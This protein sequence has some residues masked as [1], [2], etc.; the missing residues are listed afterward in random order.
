VWSGE[1]SPSSTL[2]PR[3]AAAGADLQNVGF[4]IGT[5][6]KGLTDADDIKRGFL[7][8]RDIPPLR[9][10][11]MAQNDVVLLIIDPISSVILGDSHKNAEVRRDLQPLVDLAQDND[12]AIL[13]ISHFSKG[14]G[15]RDP[16]ERVLGSIAFSGAARM[17]WAIAQKE[18]GEF[19]RVL[20]RG[21]SNNGKDRDGFE[22]RISEKLIEAQGVGGQPILLPTSHIEWGSAIE[23][24]ARQILAQAEALDEDGGSQLDYAKEFLLELL[25]EGRVPTKKA[26]SEAKAAGIAPSTLRR[27]AKSLKIKRLKGRGEEKGWFLERHVDHVDQESVAG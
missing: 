19:N 7:P 27:A 16:I 2:I 3:L 10:F 18:A 21:K 20:V 17:L 4:I 1:D 12:I 5:V 13:G 15:G 22:F 14:S 8:S 24:S 26:E 25:S 11:V 6:E 9:D 23:G